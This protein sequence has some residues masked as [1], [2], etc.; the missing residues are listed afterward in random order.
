MLVRFIAIF[1]AATAAAASQVVAALVAV[2]LM[3]ICFITATAGQQGARCTVDAGTIIF[4]L[5]RHG[6]Y[7]SEI[8]SPQIP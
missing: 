5:L 8:R 3:S 6:G 2:S 4:R 1:V 7:V